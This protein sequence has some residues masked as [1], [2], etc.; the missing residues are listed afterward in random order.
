[1]TIQIDDAGTGDIVGNAFIGFMR[2]ETGELIFKTIDVSLFQSDNWKNKAPYSKTLELVKE[3]LEEIGYKKNK[4]KL[5]L[6]RGNIFDKV[7]EYFEEEGIEYKPA[8]IEGKLQDAVEG[9]LVDHLKNDLGVKSR[10]LTKKSGKNR[11]FVLLNWVSHDFFK[12]EKYVKTGFKKWDT[13]WREI[14]MNKYY[15]FKGKKFN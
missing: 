3:G 7:R 12:R 11:Y 14:S 4:E 15:K 1:M 2:E 9:K 8:I 6:C 10:K 13:V 5:L